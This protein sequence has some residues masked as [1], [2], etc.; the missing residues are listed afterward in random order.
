MESFAR[1]N[2]EFINFYSEDNPILSKGDKC[3]ALLL[4]TIDY[5][6]PVIIR[7]EITDE[8][9]LNTIDKY[10]YVKILGFNDSPHILDRFF[11]NCEHWVHPVIHGTIQKTRQLA[12]VRDKTD[13]T[14]LRF[15]VHCFYVRK[16]YD[17]VIKLRKEYC[18]EIVKDIEQMAT[19]IDY[20]L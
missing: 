8:Y 9:F 1:I 16:D 11:F 19:E 10:Y 18:D 2:N 3:Y 6:A 20:F 4:N 7:C 13:L 14:K 17:P 5:H 15:K 12:N